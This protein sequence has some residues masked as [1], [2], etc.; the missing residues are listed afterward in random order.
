LWVAKE[1]LWPR[2]VALLPCDPAL[3][4]VDSVPVPVCR[5]A[6]APRCR[7]FRAE[8]AFGKDAGSRGFFYGLRA[9][10]RVSWPGVV[11]AV[12]LAPANR[13]D[14]EL[15]PELVDGLTGQVLADR[16][17][18]NP[19]LTAELAEAGIALL[20]PYQHRSTDPTPERSKLLNRVRRQIET[21]ASQ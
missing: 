17:Y 11:T 10:L 9:H 16:A 8:A 13:S 5:L 18:W 19:R 15:V 21:T 20:A 1:A 7:R 6:H 3:A 2:A 14:L 4:I 12:S